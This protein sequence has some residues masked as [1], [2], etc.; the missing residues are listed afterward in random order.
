MRRADMR[1]PSRIP[2]NHGVTSAKYGLTKKRLFIFNF[3]LA[4]AVVLFFCSFDWHDTTPGVR[5]SLS[6]R[7][8][9]YVFVG[10]GMLSLIRLDSADPQPTGPGLAIFDRFEYMTRAQVKVLH[11]AL[12]V[13]LCSSILPARYYSFAP[14]RH[15]SGIH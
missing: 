4:L 5:V 2:V 12:G 3:V 10:R 11:A 14:H 7:S 15:M 13:S 1:R 9:C 8:W 6:Q